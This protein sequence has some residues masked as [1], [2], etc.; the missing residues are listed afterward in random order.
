MPNKKKLKLR[1][2]KPRSTCLFYG[3]CLATT[4]AKNGKIDI[5]TVDD[6]KNCP[7]N[8]KA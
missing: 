4:L 6:Y 3:Y 1:E 5:C 8:P 7:L 2:K